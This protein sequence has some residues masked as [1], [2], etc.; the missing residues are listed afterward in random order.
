MRAYRPVPLFHDS[1]QY[2]NV[3]QHLHQ[4]RRLVTSFPH[5][6]A[7]RSHGRIPAPPTTFPPGYPAVIAAS[8]LRGNY[9]SAARIVSGICF[10]GS[11][12]LLAWALIMT[13]V[14]PFVRQTMLLLFATNAYALR[15]ST[16]V[17]TE[18]LYMFVSMAAVVTLVWM[19]ERA[20]TQRSGTAAAVIACALTGLSCWIRYAGYFLVAAV[21]LWALARLSFHQT[22]LRW[23]LPLTALIS[24]TLAGGLMLR[25]TAVVGDWRGGSGGNM[26][27]WHS[28]AN[29]AERYDQAQRELILGRRRSGGPWGDVIRIG[30]LAFA[31]LAVAA[32]LRALSTRPHREN[33]SRVAALVGLFLIVYTCGM[34][35]G[36]LRTVIS[37]GARMF[38]PE[39]TLYFLLA[40]LLINFVF[41]HCQTLVEKSLLVISLIAMTVGYAAINARDWSRPAGRPE[42][43]ILAA[44]W[45][46][47][48]ADG[49]PLKEWVESHIPAAEP[50]LSENGQATGY[51]LQH[52][53]LSMV[54]PEYSSIRWESDEVKRQ[55]ARFHAR[56]VVLYK[57][58]CTIAPLGESRFAATAAT[59]PP[60]AGFVT[61]A[62]NSCIRILRGQ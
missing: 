16:V 33:A 14:R 50:I 53:T 20:R 26:P 51:L 54:G 9:E 59:G 49:R 25:N 7:E 31:G 56:N 60:P 42:Q 61:A 5:N 19:E 58:A 8:S 24:I 6:D 34:F 46:E 37:F 28:V 38:V 47:P 21:V 43:E 44:Q 22:R 36:G 11:A 32:S 55:M 45:A 30:G 39:L 18:P 15:F 62:E 13:G 52:P 35:Y 27:V 3:A 23:V 4:E 57:P 12:A 17:L 29:V 2:L 1:Y 10:A 48:F 40:G 41:S